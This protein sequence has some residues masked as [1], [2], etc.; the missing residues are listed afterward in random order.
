MH[1]P[2]VALRAHGGNAEDPT[3]RAPTPHVLAAN[4]PTGLSAEHWLQAGNDYRA[5]DFALIS[6]C[7]SSSFSC[8]SHQPSAIF[9][10]IVPQDVFFIKQI[11]RSIQER[12]AG[13]RRVNIPFLRSRS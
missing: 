4:I 13:G 9:Y 1:P 11:Q 3:A 6:I 12:L 7:S 8:I 5:I 10:E 2:K